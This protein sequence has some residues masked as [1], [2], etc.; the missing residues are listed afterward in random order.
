MKKLMIALLIILLL[1]GC[2]PSNDDNL[3]TETLDPH[4][5][6]GSFDNEFFVCQQECE[7]NRV[8]GSYYDLYYEDSIEALLTS[9]TPNVQGEINQLV[10]GEIYLREDIP[11]FDPVS[12]NYDIP[13]F[14]PYYMFYSAVNGINNYIEYCSVDGTCDAPYS[15]S[16]QSISAFDYGF[17]EHSGYHM[18][19]T[20]DE[21]GIEKFVVIK[22]NLSLD[23]PSYE[24]LEYWPARGNF[25]YVYLYNDEYRSYTYST[26]DSYSFAY[27]NLSSKNYIDYL[28]FD[29]RET[30]KIYDPE[31]EMFY[32]SFSPYFRVSHY[33]NMELEVSLSNSNGKYTSEISL[34]SM[35]GW[36]SV[37]HYMSA[38]NFFSIVYQGEDEVF[39]DMY[40]IGRSQ[41]ISFFDF[42]GRKEITDI[43]LTSYEY[44]KEYT[45]DI[46]FDE[47]QE[48]LD[49]LVNI[50]HPLDMT[51]LTVDDIKGIMISLLDMV[52]GRYNQYNNK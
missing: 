47:M 42:I 52:S 48:E 9:I 51:V 41:V 13:I 18:R 30:V 36:D 38:T 23:N 35:T 20:K 6:L 45:G 37:K 44:P 3:Q 11:R 19:I 39:E 8:F 50:S 34:F 43:E 2:T 4:E 21:E 46:T 28:I 32:Q 7:T 5:I 24:I 27:I 10:S 22:F 33:K 15:E 12:N 17:D 16:F 29:G 31:K 14:L 40:V 25:N 26:D 49:R 1:A